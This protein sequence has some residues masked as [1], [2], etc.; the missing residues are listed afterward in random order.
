[1]TPDDGAAPSPRWT[2][3]ESHAGEVRA[4]Q[5]RFSEIGS[6]APQLYALLLEAE[7][8]WGPELSSK[9]KKVN[10]L[11]NEFTT[12][13]QL[14]LDYTDPRNK[15]ADLTAFY[16]DKDAVAAAKLIV[17]AIG[18]QEGQ[19][20]FS[21]RLAAAIAEVEDYLRPKLERRTQ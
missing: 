12:Q 21:N 5:K 16:A 18:E 11:Q 1:M 20:D 19:N 9:W 3:E 13:T 6:I 15:R 7:A 8:V 2:E 10:R 4:Y 17:K 14:Y